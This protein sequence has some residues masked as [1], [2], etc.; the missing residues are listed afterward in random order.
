M[1][2]NKTGL[3]LRQDGDTAWILG[4]RGHLIRVA[5]TNSLA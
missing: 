3:I 5:I 2:E 1:E 4:H